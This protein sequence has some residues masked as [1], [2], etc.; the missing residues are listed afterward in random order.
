M[1]KKSLFL[2]AILAVAFSFTTLKK[3][4]NKKLEP[5][6]EILQNSNIEGTYN[7]SLTYVSSLGKVVTSINAKATI[8]KE[9]KTYTILFSNDVPSLKGLIFNNDGGS[10][11]T[12]SKSNSVSGIDIDGEDLSVVVTKDGNTWAFS[13]ER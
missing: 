7:G 1:F 10:Y 11:V 5:V 9:E 13:G 2:I 3:D 6:I 12:I 4:Q 8:S